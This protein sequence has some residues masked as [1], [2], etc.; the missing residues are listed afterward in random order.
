MSQ[1]IIDFAMLLY[2]Y[3][4]YWDIIQNKIMTYIFLKAVNNTQYILYINKNKIKF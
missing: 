1:M 2:Y 4:K 3:N